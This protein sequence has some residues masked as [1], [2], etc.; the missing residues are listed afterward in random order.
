MNKPKCLQIKHFQSFLFLTT[1][2]PLQRQELP[3]SLC[4]HLVPVTPATQTGN[5]V[6]NPERFSSRSDMRV[7]YWLTVAKKFI[8]HSFC[9]PVSGTSLF[10]PTWYINQ[11]IYKSS[12]YVV[13]PRISQLMNS[14]HRKQYHTTW[15]IYIWFCLK[16][17]RSASENLLPILHTEHVPLRLVLTAPLL[18]SA[19]SDAVVWPGRLL[20]SSS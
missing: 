14:N 5:V 11:N 8:L 13:K 19:V 7:R 4:P 20:S 10:V 9:L 18:H 2:R 6:R 16:W 17:K 12:V 3:S 1:P 15:N